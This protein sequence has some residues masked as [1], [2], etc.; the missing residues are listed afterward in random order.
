V[1][2][3]HRPFFRVN[4]FLVVTSN[5]T[6]VTI[7]RPNIILPPPLAPP[8][9]PSPSPQP[10]RPP[11]PRQR[12]WGLRTRVLS[13]LVCFLCFFFFVF[14]LLTILLC[15]TGDTVTAWLVP[16]PTNDAGPGGDP[17]GHNGV[18][19]FSFR[20]IKLIIYF[21]ILH[22]HHHH[23]ATP[24]SPS[25]QQQDGDDETRTTERDQRD[26]RNSDQRGPTGQ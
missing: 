9:L 20:S 7:Q 26:P 8:P 4:L 5:G 10:L 13:P 18:F 6:H 21:H 1:T 16:A 2:L 24:P 17:P 25:P 23:D 12:Q 14:F 19:F 15:S 11:Q 3:R 22:R